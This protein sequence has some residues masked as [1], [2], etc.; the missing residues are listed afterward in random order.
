MNPELYKI[1]GLLRRKKESK[2]TIFRETLWIIKKIYPLKLDLLF[3]RSDIFKI[4]SAPNNFKFLGDESRRKLSWE[5]VLRAWIESSLVHVSE[6]LKLWD[7][8]WNTHPLS[9]TERRTSQ[10]TPLKTIFSSWLARICW[11]W[12]KKLHLTIFKFFAK[13]KVQISFWKYIKLKKK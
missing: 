1:A 13:I 2:L 10:N 7:E 6:I 12:D 3:R 9:F 5:E 8:V 4:R 11:S